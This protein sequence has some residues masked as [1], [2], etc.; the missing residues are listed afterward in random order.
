MAKRPKQASS[1][2]KA[3]KA[4]KAGN[5][6]KSKR[7]AKK[8][9]AFSEEPKS[10]FKRRG[11]KKRAG[12]QAA[13]KLG[14]G[15]GG[16][17]RRSQQPLLLAA[18][19]GGKNRVKGYLSSGDYPDYNADE[20]EDL[21]ILLERYGYPRN[22]PE[23]ARLEAASEAASFAQE[24]L[25]WRKF[26]KNK[27]AGKS[28]ELEQA[29][30]PAEAEE[31][32]GLSRRLAG[33][34]DYSLDKKATIVTIDG[35][36]AK[37]F[38]DALSLEKLEG[39][40]AKTY[41][42]GVHIADVSAFVRPGATLENEA[43]WR[44]NSVYPPGMVVPMLPAPLSEDICSLVPGKPRLALSLIMDIDENGEVTRVV[45]QRS[46][47]E[48][49][50][51]L[52]YLEVEALLLGKKSM[53][54]DIA[55]LL[56]NLLALK[57]I[58]QEKRKREGSLFLHKKEQEF[59]FHSRANVTEGKAES[60][61]P[62]LKNQHIKT[63]K[64]RER[65]ESESMVEECMLV[66]NVQAAIL[67]QQNLKKHAI[68]KQVR[69]GLSKAL[70]RVHGLPRQEEL[71]VFEKI[72]RV[73]I[74]QQFSM[75]S[76]A[77][78]KTGK[79][80]TKTS[81]GLKGK[82]NKKQAKPAGTWLAEDFQKRLKNSSAFPFFKKAENRLS[83]LLE[84]LDDSFERALLS[85]HLLRA[86]PEARY[87]TENIGHYGLAFKQYLHF[88]S[89][90]RRY[91]D[92]WTHRYMKTMLFGYSYEG[93]I[94]KTTGQSPVEKTADTAKR[95]LGLP[96]PVDIPK[97]ARYLS[98]MERK[99]MAAE[100]EFAK[101]K[102]IRFALGQKSHIYKVFISTILPS[103]DCFASCLLTG[104]DGR[105]SK[106]SLEECCQLPLYTEL[107][108][109]GMRMLCSLAKFED[110]FGEKPED[111]PLKSSSPS[112]LKTD[113]FR[114]KVGDLLKVSLGYASPEELRLGFRPIAFI[115][116]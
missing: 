7:K 111:G 42:L 23:A 10:K 87:D 99:A 62:P 54:E 84:M 105:I 108:E 18:R 37:D 112:V 45:A 55:N 113:F 88:T 92:L 9:G 40:T 85:Q 78:E 28:A 115:G 3:S 79:T 100:R 102:V 116:K 86:L 11:Q 47:I 104:I 19:R 95:K 39:A 77:D 68:K 13:F 114:I 22:F 46:L 14:R 74:K 8:A 20:K 69:F 48:S 52:S 6:W 107:A 75:G 106:E 97:V 63:I 109:D 83:F 93:V 67:V 73:K 94:L 51:R 43:R 25:V 1:A 35:D 5:A 61:A 32:W 29:A 50:A 21:A 56:R 72:A 4:S 101:L 70:F 96:L 44:A 91:A 59:S 64:L 16:S 66:A 110:A 17:S 53:A 60:L 71:A 65:L 34:K 41:R 98:F 90:I 26:N 2:G 36:E 57:N 15:G 80:K 31:G 89:P 12:K 103:G 27:L 49:R 58:L 81:A 82:A 33:R 38:D 76:R 24:I 30:A